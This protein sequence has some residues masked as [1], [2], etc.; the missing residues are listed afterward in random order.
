MVNHI[1]PK[2]LQKF[3]TAAHQCINNI[4]HSMVNH[5]ALILDYANIYIQNQQTILIRQLGLEFS[6]ISI[7]IGRNLSNSPSPSPSFL[8]WVQGFEFQ[9]SMDTSSENP[10]SQQEPSERRV[11]GSQYL[12]VKNIICGASSISCSLFSFITYLSVYFHVSR[13]LY[14]I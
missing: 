10:G 11:I 5:H 14:L 1:C 9:P 8:S 3:A 6:I 13:A 12:S 7:I 2:Q 4:N